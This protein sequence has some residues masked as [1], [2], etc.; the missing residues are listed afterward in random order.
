M[1]VSHQI[2]HLDFFGIIK[3]LEILWK[4]LTGMGEETREVASRSLHTSRPTTIDYVTIGIIGLGNLN[5][6]YIIKFMKPF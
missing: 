3:K 2:V 6:F 4:S 5:N 1:N